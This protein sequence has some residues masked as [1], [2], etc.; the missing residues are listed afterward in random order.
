METL[1]L[2]TILASEKIIYNIARLFLFIC[3]MSNWIRCFVVVDIG[4]V[5]VK[6]YTNFKCLSFRK[7]GLYVLLI[8]IMSVLMLIVSWLLM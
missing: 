5:Q 3:E 4:V 1:Q 7:I 8:P 6:C 2:F